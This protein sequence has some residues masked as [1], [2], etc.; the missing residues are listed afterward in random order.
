MITELNPRI[1]CKV[2]PLSNIAFTI[3]DVVALGKYLMADNI[4]ATTIPDL[5]PEE[6]PEVMNEF[7]AKAY[8]L[9][10]IESIIISFGGYVGKGLLFICLWM[11]SIRISDIPDQVKPRVEVMET[12]GSQ[13]PRP[14]VSIRVLLFPRA[15]KSININRL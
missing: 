2:V 15:S 9:I 12:L 6:R 4:I 13:S 7:S 8:A 3:H 1:L 14:V 11:T 10:P 5:R